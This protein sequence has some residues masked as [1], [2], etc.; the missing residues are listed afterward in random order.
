VPR[1]AARP[2]DRPPTSSPGPLQENVSLSLFECFPHVCPEPVLAKRPVL[3]THE[4]CVLS[5]LPVLAKRPKAAFGVRRFAC[6]HLRTCRNT[7]TQKQA[8]KRIISYL[9]RHF[10]KHSMQK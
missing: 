10:T 8:R 5:S 2:S 4:K 6:I 1:S 3:F 7:K 9:V